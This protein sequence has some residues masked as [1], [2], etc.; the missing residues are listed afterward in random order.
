MLVKKTFRLTEQNEAALREMAQGDGKTENE[1]VNTAISY[2][3]NRN[4][5]VRIIVNEAVSN[6]NQYIKSE[7]ENLEK[8]LKE[9]FEAILNPR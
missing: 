3:L 9:Y 5:E 6:H 1:I 7:L 4:Q 2:Y 8:H